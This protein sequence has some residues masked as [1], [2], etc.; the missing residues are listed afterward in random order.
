M[1]N[2]VAISCALAC[3]LPLA[4]AADDSSPGADAGVQEWEQAFYPAE[5]IMKHQDAIALTA[6]QRR[7]ITV[8][9]KAAQGEFVDLQFA[10]Y[11]QSRAALAL[12][13]Q[14]RIDEKAAVAAARKVME[15]ENRLKLRYLALNI[16]I[17]NALTREQQRRLDA[18]RPK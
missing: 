18:L 13:R 7:K 8:E 16:R 9:V 2:L 12:V 6:E 11:E 3:A 15:L 1:K 5:L 4:A 14:P 17:K 10:L